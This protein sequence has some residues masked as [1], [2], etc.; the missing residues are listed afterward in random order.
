MFLLQTTGST[1]KKII[2][3]LYG[4]TV[5][6]V[7]RTRRRQ[8]TR[9][10]TNVNRT[11]YRHTL[12]YYGMLQ[13]VWIEKIY[14][15]SGHIV[16]RRRQLKSRENRKLHVVFRKVFCHRFT[17][18]ISK[19]ASDT[20]GFIRVVFERYIK[21]L[22]LNENKRDDY[23]AH[24]W[25]IVKN[26]MMHSVVRPRYAAATRKTSVKQF[27]KTQSSPFAAKQSVLRENNTKLITTV[28]VHYD[29]V[30]CLFVW[31]RTIRTNVSRTECYERN[32]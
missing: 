20:L 21:Q 2:I 31:L 25:R 7:Y 3:Y 1:R 4:S 14:L 17:N 8:Q 6:I 11:M 23:G 30:A 26:V 13:R 32:Y 18:A 27:I 5:S 24:L 28:R 19:V 16:S 15:L 10:H 22:Y 12:E 29:I 9:P